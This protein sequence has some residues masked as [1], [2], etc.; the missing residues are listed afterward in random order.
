MSP[1]QLNENETQILSAIPALKEVYN[2]P[3]LGAY[4]SSNINRLNQSARTKEF[5]IMCNCIVAEVNRLY[6]AEKAVGVYKQLQ[7]LPVVETG[8]HLSFI[9][10]YEGINGYEERPLL[11]QN[12]LISSALMASAGCKYHLGVYLSGCNLTNPCSGGYYQLGT[13]VY[14]VTNKKNMGAQ[15]YLTNGISDK[16]FNPM[17]L[18]VEKIKMLYGLWTQQMK[19]KNLNIGGSQSKLLTFINQTIAAGEEGKYDKVQNLLDHVNGNHRQLIESQFV[20]LEKQAYATYGIGFS[21]VDKQYEEL[22]Q[23][24][25]RTD[26][27]LADQVALIQTNDI[28][29]ILPENG[30]EHLTIDATRVINQF[31]E[32]CMNDKESVWYQIFADTEKRN[33]FCSSFYGIRTGWKED[34]SPFDMTINLK[35]YGHSKSMAET[36]F[37]HTPE[38]IAY[39]LST[40]EITPSTGLVLMGFLS[41]SVLAHGGFFQSNYGKDF[42]GRFVE[43]LK[44]AGLNHSAAAVE[45]IPAEMILLSLGAVVKK[46]ENG[47]K[48]PLKLTEI[49]RLSN[50]KK[51]IIMKAVPYLSGQKAFENTAGILSAYLERTAPGYIAENARNRLIHNPPAPVP[52][53]TNN[54]NMIQTLTNQERIINVRN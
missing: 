33:T 21:D 48:K 12:I 23:V 27:S 37:E 35:G 34:E 3:S 20:E 19:T 50:D 9:R 36:M 54:L 43:Y 30:I 31:F 38:K 4:F 25:E 16:F 45:P 7:H 40:Q 46:T 51:E 13:S 53:V 6:G 18:W 44:N 11:S 22:R 42:Q 2:A 5:E 39:H 29:K 10:D 1:T 26:L 14:P 15:L 47:G 17:V 24:F 52:V 41:A 28:Q 32:K 8:T 49:M